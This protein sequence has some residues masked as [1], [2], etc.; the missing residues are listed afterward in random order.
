VNHIR[1]D[2]PSELTYLQH[3]SGN[4]ESV[5]DGW[6]LQEMPRDIGPAFFY[7]G[8]GHHVDVVPAAQEEIDNCFYF[9]C[10]SIADVQDFQRSAQ[11][12][13]CG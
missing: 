13:T 12:V 6:R 3:A 8:D 5:R 9:E 2:A 7:W 1:P 10:S 11:V 4:F